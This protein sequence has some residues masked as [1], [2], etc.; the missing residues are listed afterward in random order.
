LTVGFAWQDADMSMRSGTSDAALCECGIDV[1]DLR[2]PG[3]AALVTCPEGCVDG[4]A[5]TALLASIDPAELLTDTEALCLAMAWDRVT[6]WT[7]ARGLGAVAEFVRR[8]EQAGATDPLATR[9]RRRPV[10]QVAR[11]SPEAEIGPA[12]AVS[13]AAAEHRLMVATWS[14]TR[15]RPA[16]RAMRAGRIDMARL[17]ALL[18]ETAGCSDEVAEAVAAEMVAE[19]GL[20]S[21]ARF[22]REA[23][24]AV[25]R[26]DPEGA[27]ARATEQRR[28]AFVRTRGAE[29]DIA[30][31]EARLPAE[32]AHAVRTV[33][34]AAMR[35]M[36]NREGEERTADQLRAAAFVSPFWAALG[37]GELTTPQGPLQLASSG[38]TTPAL[39]L[40]E[41]AD[42]TAELTGHGVVSGQTAREVSERATSG[43]RPVVRVVPGYTPEAARRAQ[44]WAVEES[45][46]PSAPLARLVRD[47]DRTCRFPGCS[48][49]AATADLDHTVPWPAG[50]THPANLVHH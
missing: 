27:A 34:D 26:H 19:G 11:W 38:S 14:A 48:A 23:R 13:P 25:V 37:S 22:R 18:D 42:G 4:A 31:L 12:L 29:F 7:Q 17:N 8:P 35:T 43:P 39:T 3:L 32:D 21:A 49:V 16:L 36:A 6:A 15:L 44:D 2:L 24:R 20:T 46:R 9:S 33:L 41:H 47:R 40:V 30:W 28:N 5:L 10:G 45:Y 50:P 1:G